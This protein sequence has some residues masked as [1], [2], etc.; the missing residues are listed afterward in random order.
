MADS[1]VLYVLVEPT[2]LPV[3]SDVD[4]FLVFFTTRNVSAPTRAT[5]QQTAD[6]AVLLVDG[7]KFWS[8]KHHRRCAHSTAHREQV[9]IS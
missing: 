3:P 7:F 2:K 6:A 9:V 5:R 1:V 8:D 4:K